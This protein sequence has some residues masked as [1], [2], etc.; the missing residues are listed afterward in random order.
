MCVAKLFSRLSNSYR[1]LSSGPSRIALGRFEGETKV[2]TML[3]SD[4]C[5]HA[6]LDLIRVDPD[7]RSRGLGAAML[8]DLC[9]AADATGTTLL[10]S[11]VPGAHIDEARLTRWYE[12]SGF[13]LR[14]DLCFADD[15]VHLRMPCL[16]PD[17]AM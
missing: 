3:I 13:L 15:R 6:C 14:E 2:A 11:V 17:C 1:V 10:L 7:H 16:V 9:E 5:G 4:D 12:A 8:A